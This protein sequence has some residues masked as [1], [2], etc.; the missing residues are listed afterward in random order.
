MREGAVD[1]SGREETMDRDKKAGR[2]RRRT[3]REQARRGEAKPAPPASA[4]RRGRPLEEEE[5]P[6]AAALHACK[7]RGFDVIH[8]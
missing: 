3:R 8:C 5:S 2:R 6:R 4:V 7:E 1:L